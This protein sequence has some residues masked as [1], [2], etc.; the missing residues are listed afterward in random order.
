MTDQVYVFQG[1]RHVISVTS[2]TLV[3]NTA[4]EILITVPSGKRWMLLSVRMVNDDDVARTAT[5]FKYKEVAKTNVSSRLISQ[6]LNQFQYAQW[7][8]AIAD[9]D[10]RGQPTQPTEIMSEGHTLS[11]QWSD[12][13]AS[14][15]SVDADGL[16]I[17][18]LEMSM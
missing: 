16:V 13:G 8:N 18:Y 10:V 5:C 17:E 7:P 1:G 11:C 15:G 14:T 2:V 6:S 12:P 4:K 9:I 3:D